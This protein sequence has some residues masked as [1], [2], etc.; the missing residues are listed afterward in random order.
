MAAHESAPLSA[1]ELEAKYEVERIKRMTEGVRTY[2]SLRDLDVD[3]DADPYTPRIQRDVLTEET[4]VV[5][6]GT[7]LGRDEHRGVPR[8]GGRHQL[9]DARQGRRLRRH[10][11]LEPLP[12]LHVR[13]RG[14]HL[15]PAARGGRLHADQEVRPRAGDL[16]VRPAARAHT[17]TCTPTPCSTPRRPRWSGTT[18]P[19]AGRSSPTAA[20]P[21]SARFVVICGGVLHKAKLPGIPGI[22]TFQGRSFHTSRWDYAYTGG[23]PEVPM[24]KLARQEGRHHRHRR[25]R[26]A[27]RAEAGRGRRAALRVPA[28]ALV[29]EP[30]QP[31][32]H[33]PRVVGRDD[34]R[35]GLARAAHGE[36]HR[37]DD[38]RQPARRP[39]PGRLDGDVR[40]RREEGAGRRGRGRRAQGARLPADGRD[41]P[42]HRRHRRGPGHGR[43]AQ[44]LVRRQLQ[45]ALLP[46]RLPAG[47]QPRQRH[48][49]RH[50]RPGRHRHHREGP[51]GRRHRVRG[52]LH[53]LRHR[54]RLA[55][56]LL[57]APPRLRPDRPRR[58]L[59]VGLVGQGGLDR[60]TASGPT[61]SRTWR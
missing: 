53:R 6:I 24:D 48:A 1:E 51:G 15:P 20:T 12:G 27:G 34:L 23:A 2:R 31:A 37:H 44:A 49:R 36:L 60:C 56:R 33:R 5:I 47:V 3:F 16:R 40:G 9:P 21:L 52:R 55:E 22:E 61:A 58:H 29:G 59:D 32:R 39:H 42:A 25:H 11:V 43:G 57:H 46:R 30:P 13:R 38:R 7:G 45:A 10:L 17:S 4:D 14:V 19:S 50:R 28:H 8:Q 41:P 54:L 26:G 35:A 18:T